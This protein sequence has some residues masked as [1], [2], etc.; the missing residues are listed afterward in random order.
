[1]FVA[2]RRSHCRAL[3]ALLAATPQLRNIALSPNARSATIF[4]LIEQRTVFFDCSAEQV[5]SALDP[6]CLTPVV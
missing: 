4:E 3:R 1:V 5:C 2:A 6:G